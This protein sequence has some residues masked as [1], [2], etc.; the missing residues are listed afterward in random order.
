MPKIAFSLKL[1]PELMEGA[2]Y[3]AEKEMRPIN[4]L[5]KF[6]LKQYLDQAK[7]KNEMVSKIKESNDS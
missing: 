6:A 1:K 4:N 5:I 7:K 3:Q 2:V